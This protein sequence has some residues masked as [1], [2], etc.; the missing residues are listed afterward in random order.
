MVMLSI[1][2][3]NFSSQPS[4]HLKTH[5]PIQEDSV[6]KYLDRLLERPNDFRRRVKR[7]SSTI[8]LQ[9][10]YRY[11]LSKEEDPIHGSGYHFIW[12]GRSRSY[13]VDYFPFRTIASAFL[14]PLFPNFL[15][16]PFYFSWWIHTVRAAP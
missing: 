4:T 13:M 5:W 15:L 11:E 10:A 12:G 7:M 1:V 6:H 16:K 14:L 8:I 9:M 3:A 2:R